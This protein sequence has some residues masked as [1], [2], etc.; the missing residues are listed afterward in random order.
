MSC[1]PERLLT[2]P[3]FTVPQEEKEKTLLPALVALTEHH[4]KACPAYARM[5]DGAFELSIQS[6]ADV[7]Y[8]PVSLFKNRLLSSVPQEDV[9][10]TIKSSGTTGM[11]RSQIQMDKETAR[12]SSTCLAATL[13]ELIGKTRLPLL[14]ADTEA[15]LSPSMDMGARAAALLGIM[16]FGR[17]PTF[18]L[19]PDLTL[20]Q[21]KLEGFMRR[22]AD[23]PFLIYGF[24]FLVW[25]GLLPAAQALGLDLSKAVLLHSGG[26]KTLAEKAVS[27]EQFNQT[28]KQ[29]TGLSRIIN[30]YGMAEMPGVIFAENEDGLLYPPAFADV[31]VRD[32]LSFAPVA[33]GETG[34]VQVLSTIPHSFPGHAIL[35]ED[36]GMIVKTDNGA[37]GWKGHGLR[38]LGRLPKAELRGCSD[39]IAQAQ[40]G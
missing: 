16:P 5:V 3:L 8:L 15:A 34:V 40:K 29:A 14:L 1:F 24:T 18:M 21:E 6:M 35:T 28:L 27:R 23:A 17:D 2:Q 25:L 13:K 11:A 30:F 19:K 22:Y 39:V 7:P 36:L 31:I 12:L 38:L 37:N 9:R 32:P 26:W 4:R 33:E 20:D 10:V